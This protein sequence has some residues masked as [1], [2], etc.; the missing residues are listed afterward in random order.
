MILTGT[1]KFT[2]QI[3]CKIVSAGEKYFQYQDC[4]K[5]FPISQYV[6]IDKRKK[7]HYHPH[8]LFTSKR[9]Q[10]GCLKAHLKSH[11]NEKKEQKFCSTLPESLRLNNTGAK[12]Y[13]CRYCQ[14]VFKHKSTLKVHERIHTGEK[15]YKCQHCGKAF[16]QLG[17]LKTHLRT[18]T[19]E[20]PYQCQQCSRGFT[21]SSGLNAHLR[22]HTREKPF[23]CQHCSKAFAT[24]GGLK[25][26]LA[27][28]NH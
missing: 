8:K 6:N 19:G 4:D 17:N 28:L 10:V 11:S 14:K 13:K 25:H 16:T 20:K 26:H 21:Q 7:H 27:T 5:A 3:Q 9:K 1:I 18:H 15:P 24:S 23:Q 22:T 2:R 12:P